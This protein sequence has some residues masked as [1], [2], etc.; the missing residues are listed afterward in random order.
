MRQLLSGLPIHL[1]VHRLPT[2]PAVWKRELLA[3][4]N[5]DVGLERLLHNLLLHSNL[6]AAIEQVRRERE[7]FHRDSQRPE[8]QHQITALREDHRAELSLYQR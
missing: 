4:A 8:R 7:S 1:A 2:R 6:H 5:S 3:V